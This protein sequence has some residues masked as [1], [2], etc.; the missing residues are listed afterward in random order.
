MHAASSRN[1]HAANNDP[2]LG[3]ANLTADLCLLVP[4][5]HVQGRGDELHA[6]VVF[7]ESWGSG[8]VEYLSRRFFIVGLFIMRSQRSSS[9]QER[10]I[11]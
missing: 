2:S 11:F 8:Q 5:G 3:E 10:R 9:R 4:A 7:P 6:D 1:E